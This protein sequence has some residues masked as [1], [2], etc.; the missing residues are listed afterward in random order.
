[1][2]EERDEWHAERVVLEDGSILCEGGR[3]LRRH[4]AIGEENQICEKGIWYVPV[5]EEIIDG[6]RV[7]TVRP[8]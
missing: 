8:Q 4:Y 3:L 5:K 2:S 6:V 7:V 1:M